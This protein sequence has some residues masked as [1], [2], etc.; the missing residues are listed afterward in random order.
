MVSYFPTKPIFWS[1]ELKKVP[2]KKGSSLGYTVR[3]FKGSVNF[4]I[5]FLKLGTH[6]QAFCHLPNLFLR[7][8]KVPI[9]F[10]VYGTPTY[11]CDSQGK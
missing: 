10:T 5:L 8:R 6:L 11:G 9:F 4:F 1:T 2:I 7:F 3:S